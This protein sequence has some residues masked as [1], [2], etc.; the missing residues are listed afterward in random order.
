MKS[1]YLYFFLFCLSVTNLI[2]QTPKVLNL[3]QNQTIDLSLFA[4]FDA[5]PNDTSARKMSIKILVNDP[6]KTIYEKT[7]AVYGTETT[8]QKPTQETCYRY[9]FRAPGA[10]SSF[11]AV[12]FY[13]DFEMN[14]QPNQQYLL[15]LNT[16]D[17]NGNF[18]AQS[19][20][21]FFTG[22]KTLKPMTVATIS[23]M[24][25][26]GVFHI[27]NAYLLYRDTY[28]IPMPIQTNH[29][30]IKYTEG[31]FYDPKTG[32]LVDINY[33]CGNNMFYNLPIT[34]LPFS[35][36]RLVLHVTGTDG[37]AI[38]YGEYTFR[39]K[40]T[41]KAKSEIT[42]PRDGQT[43]VSLTPIIQINWRK[44]KLSLGNGRVSDNSF[45]IHSAPEL[46]AV[47]SQEKVEVIYN[48]LNQ[49]FQPIRKLRPNTTYKLT[50]RGLYNYRGNYEIPTLI[51]TFTT[52]AGS[53][54]PTLS[55]PAPDSRLDPYVNRGFFT[56]SA[57]DSTARKLS[58]KVFVNDPRQLIWEETKDLPASS[59]NRPDVTF[60]KSP[61]QLDYN[62]QYLAEVATL[63]GN[64]QMIKQQYYTFFTSLPL[65]LNPYPEL[66]TPAQS[67]SNV[68]LN[69]V[70]SVK[71]PQL[72]FYGEELQEV[73][74]ALDTYPA[75]WSGTD[76]QSESKTVTT[77]YWTPKAA[78][79][80]QW[81]PTQAL[82]PDT[83]YQV[84][85][86]FHAPGAVKDQ[87]DLKKDFTFT[88]GSS[89]MRL[90]GSD[91]RYVSTTIAMPNPFSNELTI[92]LDK[93]YTQ[94]QVQLI[95]MKGQI[96]A[97]QKGSAQKPIVFCGDN[98][99][100]GL[101]VVRITDATGKGEQFK[102]IKQ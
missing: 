16:Y 14:M 38:S 65:T 34:A 56:A 7:V 24:E 60:S 36:L 17:R 73:Y 46:S 83:K 53:E 13:R 55:Y 21:T 71:A 87:Y 31:Y 18:L 101:Y 49:T 86:I 59:T 78:D 1:L 94:A 8:L 12:R 26:T 11:T 48:Y 92:Q 50:V 88:T 96:L 62:Q 15:E 4:S 75:D 19:Y 28:L 72:P 67:A 44:N 63:D 40:N 47:D 76:Y 98:L 35:E 81:A 10:S 89:T 27:H 41:P 23:Y 33:E 39:V 45:A 95:G 43:N 82:K 30:E 57:N 64:E 2:A 6:R 77:D 5:V 58:L 99:T 69:P 32:K 20:T 42:Y 22:S 54:K 84:R 102:V 79:L 90:S 85:I 3:T 37:R 29:P 68:S 9:D 74:Y 91:S 51:S 25:P 61:E 97:Q 93:K 80:Y 52:G 70:I 66:V 100:P